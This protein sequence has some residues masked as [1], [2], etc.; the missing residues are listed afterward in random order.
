MRLFSDDDLVRIVERADRYA[1][2]EGGLTAG[3]IREIGGSLGIPAAAME[4]AIGAETRQ[5]LQQIPVA[6][7][8]NLTT[9]TSLFLAIGRRPG[10][11][12][13]LVLRLVLTLAVGTLFVA[14]ARRYASEGPDLSVPLIVIA[15]IVGLQC[16]RVVRT[17]ATKSVF[18]VIEDRAVFGT[19]GR[20]GT[21]QQALANSVRLEVKS[22]PDGES[23]YEAVP[24]YE[25]VVHGPASAVATF[26]GIDRGALE[27]L[28]ATFE[29]W[30]SAQRV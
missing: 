28:K 20:K 30:Q 11:S 12:L 4:K 7:K 1:Q 8:V 14:I 22:V 6:S 9:G 10:F 24:V 19:I 29:T 26:T 5:R 15:A 13:P 21:L 18:M 23:S 17:A 16:Y 27:H 3:E 25:L 2:S